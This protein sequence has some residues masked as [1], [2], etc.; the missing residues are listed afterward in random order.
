ME[1]VGGKVSM[2]AP[3]DMH[4]AGAA[5]SGTTAAAYVRRIG[6]L[7]QNDSHLGLVGR[8]GGFGVKCSQSRLEG[9]D[10]LIS[11]DQRCC[12][13]VFLRWLHLLDRGLLQALTDRR[14]CVACPLCC[15]QRTV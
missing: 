11:R 8:L 14:F 4:M 15:L 3:L 12:G 9:R 7:V 6:A 10:L 1:N 2:M 13:L 5:Q